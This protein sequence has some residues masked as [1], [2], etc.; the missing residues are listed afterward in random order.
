MYWEAAQNEC[1]QVSFRWGFIS[2]WLTFTLMCRGNTWLPWIALRLLDDSRWGCLGFND[3]IINSCIELC[4]VGHSALICPLSSTKLSGFRFSLADHSITSLDSACSTFASLRDG[5]DRRT[6]RGR[7]KG[8]KVRF[9]KA[10]LHSLDSI[11]ARN[12]WLKAP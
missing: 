3:R 8:F 11:P 7:M 4:F 10:L 2:M 6:V 9:L 5:E 1:Y 12:A